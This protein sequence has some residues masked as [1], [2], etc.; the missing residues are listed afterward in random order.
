MKYERVNYLITNRRD[1]HFIFDKYL[2]RCLK[3][4]IGYQNFV[5]LT[6]IQENTLNRMT[7]W[8][9]VTTPTYNKM[10]EFLNRIPEKTF[11]E[12]LNILFADDCENK[13]F[14]ERL[15]KELDSDNE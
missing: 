13:I 1:K 2:I 15:L 4:M 7:N 12:L 8:N 9:E 11:D 5:K 10:N 6:G 14:G 3:K